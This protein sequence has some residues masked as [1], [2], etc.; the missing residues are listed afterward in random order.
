[1]NSFII[2]RHGETENNVHGRISGWTDSPLT[3]DSLPAT[4]AAAAKVKS[5]SPELLYSSDLGRSFI[6]A[7]IIARSI[8]YQD[9]IVRLPGL[10]ECS[11]GDLAYQHY[12]PAEAEHPGLNR[13]TDYIPPN[14]ESLGQMQ[15]R[16][17]NTI[18]DLDSA[19]TDK[20][21]LLVAHDGVI[22]AVSANFTGE[23]LGE[24]NFSVTYGHDYVASFGIAD[25]SIIAFEEVG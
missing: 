8:G 19:Y 10:R 14:G 21:I 24:H 1:V 2:C 11:Y 12:G 22:K 25:G 18:A 13:Q 4:L 15:Q 16:V 23:D 9:E 7:Y 17:I 20:T 3:S 6:T 5:K